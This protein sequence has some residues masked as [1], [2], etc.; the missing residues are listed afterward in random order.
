MFDEGLP[1]FWDER[2]VMLSKGIYDDKLTQE[3]IN[4][5]VFQDIDKSLKGETMVAKLENDFDILSQ[6]C[7]V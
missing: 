2:K 5:Q 3:K 1:Y 4:H 7:K 6:L